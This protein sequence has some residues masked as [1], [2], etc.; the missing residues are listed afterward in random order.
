MLELVYLWVEN[1]KN[2]QKQGFNF[3]P[4][5]ECKFHDEYDDDGKLKD[6]CELVICDKKKKECKDNDYIENFFGENINVT[7]IVGKNGSGKSSVFDSILDYIEYGLVKQYIVVFRDIKKDLKYT[8]NIEIL[9]DLLNSDDFKNG[10]NLFV[11]NNRNHRH[12]AFRPYNLVEVDKK[13]IANILSVEQG[14]PNT[15]FNISTFMYLPTKIEIKL[16]EAAELI[17]GSINFFP[18]KNMGEVR[19]IFN[20]IDNNYRQFLFIE[21]GRKTGIYYKKEVLSDVEKIKEELKDFL[22]ESDYHKY[23]T[24][25]IGEKVFNISDLNNEEKNIYIREDGYF[26]FFDF[27]MIDE[28][29][30]RFNSLSHGEQMIFGQLLNIYFFS[31]S[32]DN[33]IFLFDEPELALHPNWQK[34]YLHEVITLCQKM[35]KEYQ[36]IFTTHSPFLLSDIP[37]Q[38]IIFLDKDENGNCL[39]VDGLKE[40]KQTFG[41]NIHTLLSDSFFMED[42]LMGEFAKSKIDKVIKL[43]NQ[44][45]LH[46]DELKYCE[47]IISIIGEPIIKSQLQRMLDSKRLSKIDDINKK[48]KDMSYELEILKEHQTKIVQ[49]ELRNKGKKQ[50][51]QRLQDD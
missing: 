9:T 39:I 38:N 10:R 34:Q 31:I 7:A 40:K 22:S 26:H 33:L 32:R 50:Y 41:A 51:K 20:S 49:D 11:Y 16:R 23:F 14:K 15:T 44:E 24:T 1:Y 45:R 2:I 6:N 27:D 29:E 8:A 19:T 28:Q 30:R 46:E 25:L 17:E 3:S 36:F 5:F 13:S 4:R 12:F 47:Q 37:K 43:L 18:P 48:I 42:G 21:Y 35:K